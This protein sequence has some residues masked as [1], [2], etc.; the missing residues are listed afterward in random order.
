MYAC[1]YDY[2]VKQIILPPLQHGF[3]PKPFNCN[4]PFKLTRY[5]KI[6]YQQ[7]LIKMNFHLEYLLTLL[8]HYDQ[9]LEKLEHLGIHGPATDWFHKLPW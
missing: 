1:L 8:K 9:L 5:L 6:V 7:L 4:V 2:I 3:Q